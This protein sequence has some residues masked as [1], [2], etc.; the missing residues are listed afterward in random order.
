MP[1]PNS[2]AEKRD[3]GQV[4]GQNH[5]NSGDLFFFYVLG[6]FLPA[7]VRKKGALWAPPTGQKS[8]LGTTPEKP[9]LLPGYAARTRRATAPA[10][11]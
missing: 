4:S 2:H 1:L 8:R 3:F 7:Q 10:A 9:V 11:R 5:T 6:L